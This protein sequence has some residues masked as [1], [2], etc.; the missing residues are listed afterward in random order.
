MLKINWPVELVES[1]ILCF[2]H[3]CRKEKRK[4]PFFVYNAWRKREK[5]RSEVNE[6]KK[7]LLKWIS[8]EGV[9]CV[10]TYLHLY[11]GHQFYSLW[12][13]WWSSSCAVCVLN[14][15]IVVGIQTWGHRWWERNSDES[16]TIQYN[17][18]SLS[19]TWRNP[20]QIGR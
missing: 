14:I 9:H 20:G 19:Y 5:F 1:F 18:H 3:V 11:L 13:W 17:T 15:E 12:R 8:N 6:C 7:L 4:F 10:H 16:H 2:L